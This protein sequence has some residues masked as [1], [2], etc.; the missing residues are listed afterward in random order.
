M[1]KEKFVG[2]KRSLLG[3]MLPYKEQHRKKKGEEV[4]DEWGRDLV[5]TRS[6]PKNPKIKGGSQ[7]RGITQSKNGER[8]MKD[9]REAKFTFP[10]M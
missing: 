1:E 8:S 10:K 9:P 5:H 2:Q 7:S 6:K 3:K 4:K